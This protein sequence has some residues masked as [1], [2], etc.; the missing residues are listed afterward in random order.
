MFSFGRVRELLRNSEPQMAWVHLSALI[1]EVADLLSSE[2][3]LRDVTLS[4][5][6]DRVPV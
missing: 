1:R 2:A 6:F 3:I 5:S 4:L